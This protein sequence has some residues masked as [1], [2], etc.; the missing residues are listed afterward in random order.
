MKALLQHLQAAGLSPKTDVPLAK[1]GYW[2]LGGPADILVDVLDT[3]GLQAVMTTGAPVTVLGNGSNLLVAD[4]GIRGIT[5]RLKGEFLKSEATGEILTAGGGLMNTVL[6]A[7]LQKI[8]LGG[9]G[10]LAGVPGTLGGAI[11]MNAGTRLG[12][13]GSRVL[14][15]EVVL[16]G[17][18]RQSLS[19]DEIGFSYR[20][21]RLPDGAI[22]TRAQLQLSQEI[23]AEE[24]EAMAE[25]ID[26]RKRTQ[27]LDQPSCGSV[28]KNPQGDHAGRLIE[29]V[30][31]KGHKHGGARISAKHANFIV[32]EGGATAMDVH[33][34]IHLAQET[35][36]E[37][38]GVTLEPEVHAV[39][40]WPDGLWPL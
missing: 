23:Y 7:R 17:G 33:H 35:V 39:G 19:P 38:H 10:C 32:N 9:L 4:E 34:L 16:P 12:E 2:R 8:Q 31:L 27:P 40:D 29:D 25:H 36:Q 21:A 18:E 37:R 14:W 6:L 13:I 15:V 26:Y 28:F 5:I 1:Y 20:W 30:G 11:R 3:E 22:I 24:R